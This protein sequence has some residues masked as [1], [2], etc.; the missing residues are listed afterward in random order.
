MKKRNILLTLLAVAGMLTATSCKDYLD[1]MPDNRAELDSE[2][3][4]ISLLVSAYPENDYIFCTELGT[5]NV[6]DFGESNPYGDRFMEQIYNWQVISEADNEDPSRI[7]EACY[8]AIAVA[9]QA[10]ASIAEMEETSAMKAA[11]GEA[12]VCR[13][14][15]HFILVNVFAQHYTKANAGTDL[16]ITYMEVSETE[17]DPKYERNT[18]AEVYEKI[19]KDLKEGLPL[20]SDEIYTVPKYHFN[21][22]AAYAFAARFY[23]YYQKWQEAIDCATKA[24]GSSPAG[25]LRDYAALDALPK[26]PFSKVCEQYV[27]ATVKANYLLQTA[28]SRLGLVFTS[29]YEGSRYAHGAYLAQTETLM[30]RAPWGTYANKV[31]KFNLWASTGTNFDKTLVP[32]FP[33]L[34]EYTDPV[35]QTGYARTVYAALTAEETLLIRA[36]A[37][38]LQKEYDKALADLQVWVNNTINGPYTLTKEAIENWVDSYQYYTP[39][40]PTPKKKL[41]P[42]FA[43][44]EGQ[45]EAYLQFLLYARRYETMFSGLRWFDIKRY[46][47]EI[48]RRTMQ[49]GQP[50]SIGD[51]LKV[52]DNRCA[53]QIPPDVISAGITPNPR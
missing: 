26:D 36:E 25:Q 33:Y 49:S 29:Y 9:N 22:K 20:I 52:R 6:D 41:N 44:E 23:L 10:L 21:M 46:G 48:Y 3:K 27:S 19:E 2:S 13:A 16:G 50:V 30:S 5:D 53:L 1:E 38:I 51:M 43:I 28:Y 37:Y 24:L 7:W 34:I 14:Y 35:A 32:R 47:I 31:Y 8:N 18:V 12:L 42:E 40:A 17:L 4:I 11:K 45:Q 15:L 39:N